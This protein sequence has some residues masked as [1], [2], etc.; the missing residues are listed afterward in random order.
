MS[1]STVRI[2]VAEPFE[3]SYGN[4]FGE[5]LSERNGDNLKVRLT[6]Q[7]NG[8]S[9]SSDIIL[10]TPRFKDE[11]FKPLQKKYSVTVN[12]SLINEETNEQEFIIVGNVTYD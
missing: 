7:I 5:I 11:T 6:Q 3:W 9:F 8:K 4:L 12:G 1:K 10:L 2:V